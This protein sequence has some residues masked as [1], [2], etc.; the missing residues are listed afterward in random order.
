MTPLKG[1]VEIEFSNDMSSIILVYLGG[2]DTFG[3]F[4]LL[5]GAFHDQG[6]MV[7]RSTLYA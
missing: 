6:K 1:P 4:S 3:G 5:T 2:V 7:M